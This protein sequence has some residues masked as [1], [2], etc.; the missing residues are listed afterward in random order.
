M[1]EDKT[2]DPSASDEA[3]DVQITE[4]VEHDAS[5]SMKGLVEEQQKMMESESRVKLEVEAAKGK[6]P[7]IPPVKITFPRRK[8]VPVRPPAPAKQP[9]PEH[10]DETEDDDDVPLRSLRSHKKN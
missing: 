3:A 5:I 9:S 2:E 6:D 7:K 10:D 4:T 1:E 8:A